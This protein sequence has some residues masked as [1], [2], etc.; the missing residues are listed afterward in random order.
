MATVNAYDIGDE[1][2][3]TG[4]FT[5][6]ASALADPTTI[7]F[8]LRTPDGGSTSLVY[9]TDAALTRSTTGTYIVNWLTSAP[10]DYFYRYVGT[11]NVKSAG[12]RQFRV[13]GSRFT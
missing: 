13:K 11:G 12:E 1:V 2:T 10:G 6:T 9:G 8:R 5:D 7:T 4:V 3:L